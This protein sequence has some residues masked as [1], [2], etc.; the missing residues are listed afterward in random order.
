VICKYFL[1]DLNIFIDDLNAYPLEQLKLIRSVLEL[2][3][4]S[5]SLI[6]LKVR[7]LTLLA[8]NRFHEAIFAELQ[9]ENYPLDESLHICK[10]YEVHEA[11]AYLLVK[12]GGEGSTEAAIRVYFKIIEQKIAHLFSRAGEVR[13]EELEEVILRYLKRCIEICSEVDVRFHHHYD[14]EWFIIL[15]ELEHFKKAML[16]NWIVDSEHCEAIRL[17]INRQAYPALVQSLLSQIEQDHVVMYLRRMMGKFDLEALQIIIEEMMRSYL[18]EKRIFLIAELLLVQAENHNRAALF[19]EE[20]TLS[21]CSSPALPPTRAAASAGSAAT[22]SSTTV[23][24]TRT[25]PPA[26]TTSRTASSARPS[27]R[28]STG[29]RSAASLACAS[30]ST[31]AG[32]G[33]A[34]PTWSGRSIGRR[35]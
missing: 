23:A 20:V 3:A 2:Y 16:C 33:R 21:P 27:P 32:R 9:K 34:W 14:N 6:D 13:R 8:A 29:A 19:R 15:E 31:R 25:T 17:I 4:Y 30:T 11:L 5:E 35:S 10:Q 12:S 22:C 26:V 24:A 7:Y 28:A 1:S 18:Y